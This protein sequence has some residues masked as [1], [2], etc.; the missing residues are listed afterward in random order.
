M[1]NTK[2][3]RDTMSSQFPAR[4]TIQGKLAYN[5]IVSAT[6]LRVV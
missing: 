6:A 2:N 3:G 4:I 5:Y 1:Q